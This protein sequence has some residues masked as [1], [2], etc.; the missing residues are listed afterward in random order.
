MQT[1]RNASARFWCF[2]Q[3]QTI[4]LAALSNI[5]D[6]PLL[7][8]GG[9]R[10]KILAAARNAGE[11]AATRLRCQMSASGTKLP[12]KAEHCLLLGVKRTWRGLV[13]DVR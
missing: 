10:S 3:I 13:S 12:L 2:E 6:F 7:E 9:K 4:R 11:A 8:Y 5:D 1:S